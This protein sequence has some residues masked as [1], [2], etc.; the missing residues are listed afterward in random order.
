MNSLSESKIGRKVK[1]LKGDWKVPKRAE[2]VGEATIRHFHDDYVYH[3]Q[4][5]KF[6]TETEKNKEF[7]LR[8]CYY[9]GRTYGQYAPVIPEDELLKLLRKARKKGILSKNFR[10]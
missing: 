5:L 6:D 4:K 1:M 9:K 10:V 2:V 3:L 7:E 8:F